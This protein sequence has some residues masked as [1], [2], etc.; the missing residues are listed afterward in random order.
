MVVALARKHPSLQTLV[1][2]SLMLSA[3]AEA[4][5][6]LTSQRSVLVCFAKPESQMQEADQVSPPKKDQ[7]DHLRGCSRCRILVLRVRKES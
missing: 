3:V 6:A 7:V 4:V 5:E 1:R 2:C